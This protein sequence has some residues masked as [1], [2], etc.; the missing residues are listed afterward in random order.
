MLNKELE[1]LYKLKKFDFKS[2]PSLK[3]IKIALEKLDNFHKKLKVIHV[4][5][6]NGKGSCSAMISTILEKA[7]IKAGL[8]TSPHLVKYN[9]RIKI[10]NKNIKDEDIL[11]LINKIKSINVALSF[12]EFTTVLA[13]YYFYENNVDYVI[14]EVGLGGTY[15]ATNVCD[16]EIAVITD[17]CLDHT[18][19]LG[20][21]I[22]EIAKEKCG[23]IKENSKVV[24]EENNVA[25]DII[26][27]KSKNNKLIIAKK[28]EGEIGLKGEFQKRNAGIAYSV[29]KILNIDEEKIKEGIKKAKWPGR[30]EYLEQ[31]IL[32][33]CAHNPSAIL[34]ITKFVKNLKYKK[35]II[36]FGVLE[37][38]DFKKMIK[39]LPKPDFLILTKPKIDFALE[40]TQLAH[41][42]KCAVIEEPS[43]A[44]KFAKRLAREED[45]ILITGS[46]YLVG[47]ILETN[48]K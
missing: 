27:E 31:N 3:Q 40:P 6:T 39:Q 12:F 13:L 44:L 14:L 25:L 24:T 18:R 30:L 15:D 4:T 21:T 10:N 41:D 9:E 46:C 35:L 19:I 7:D 38:K 42:G 26:K 11:R 5:G 29:G 2:K 28:Y 48:K 22:E 45:L 1:Y 33:D 8:Y 34:E 16:A 37:R 43:A 36:I 32:L 20:N 17:I 23:I 47:N